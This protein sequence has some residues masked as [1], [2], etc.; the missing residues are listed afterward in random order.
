MEMAMWKTFGDYLEGSGWTDAHKQELHHLVFSHLT[1]T[2]HAH[3]V[4]AV[5][6]A[7]LQT[8]AFLCTEGPH[9]EDAKEV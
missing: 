2:R 7:R 5:A 4:T 3:Q 9:D 8:D 6:L 1:R